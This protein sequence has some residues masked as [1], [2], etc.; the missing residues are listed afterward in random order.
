MALVMIVLI[1]RLR[2]LHRFKIKITCGVCEHVEVLFNA[3][4]LERDI[5]TAGRSGC[6]GFLQFPDT[7]PMANRRVAMSGR[8]NYRPT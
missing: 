4:S 7:L 1:H 3:V 6:R 2:R 8:P 5:Q